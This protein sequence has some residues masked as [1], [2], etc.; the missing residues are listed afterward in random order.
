[1]VVVDL[2]QYLV[3]HVVHP[4]AITQQIV[5]PEHEQVRQAPTED[6]GF[7]LCEPA[8]P[9]PKVV[10]HFER[11]IRVG[12]ERRQRRSNCDA[13]TAGGRN[14]Y[15]SRTTARLASTSW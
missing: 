15:L 6:L 7:T 14:A 1:M 10:N 3:Q 4:N 11:D 2:L 13:D 12:W 8:Y 9:R 5:R